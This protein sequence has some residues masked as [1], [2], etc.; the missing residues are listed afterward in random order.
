MFAVNG[1]RGTCHHAARTCEH[2]FFARNSHQHRSRR[3]GFIH[4]K[5]CQTK[6]DLKLRSFEV[7]CNR[8]PLRG[9]S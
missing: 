8:I 2:A 3:P 6:V 9:C 7:L 5:I 1:A 4:R